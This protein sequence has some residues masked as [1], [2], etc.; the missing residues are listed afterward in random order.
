M[1]TRTR[2]EKSSKTI[3]LQFISFCTVA[4]HSIVKDYW[5]FFSAFFFILCSLEALPFGPASVSKKKSHHLKLEA[6]EPMKKWWCSSWWS[7][8]A[9]KGKKWCKDHGNS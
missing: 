9:Q 1:W 6:Y 5:T 4:Y 8:P 2:V 7:A 3:K